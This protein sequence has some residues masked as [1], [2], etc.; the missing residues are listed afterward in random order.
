M[1]THAE[2]VKARLDELRHDAPRLVARVEE[3]IETFERGEVQVS[4][5]IAKQA[6]VEVRDISRCHDTWSTPSRRAAGR[7]G[8][9]SRPRAGAAPRAQK[10]MRITTRRTVGWL[11]S[12]KPAAAKMLRLPTC[13]STRH[14]VLPGS[15][16][17][18]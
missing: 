13:S 14:D 5:E 1:S 7:R 9:C 10:S 17:I 3:A 12:S 11:T 4:C 16:I 18:G 6:E 2:E 15:V 8:T